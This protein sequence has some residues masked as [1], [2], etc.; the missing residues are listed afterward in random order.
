MSWSLVSGPQNTQKN[1]KPKQNQ[2]IGKQANAYLSFLF[3]VKYK[4]CLEK[5]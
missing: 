4:K 3:T 5:Y 1:K 2:L